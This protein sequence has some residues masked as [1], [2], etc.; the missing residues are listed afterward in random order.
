MTRELGAGILDVRAT[1]PPNTQLSNER[2]MTEIETAGVISRVISEVWG[3]GDLN[4]ADQLFAPGYIN[5][6]GFTPDAIRGPESIKLAVALYRKAFPEL[7][8]HNRSPGPRGGTTDVQLESAKQFFSRASARRR[9][10]QTRIYCWHD[11][12]P[13]RSRPDRRE[14]D[15]SGMPNEKCDDSLSL[16]SDYHAAACLKGSDLRHGGETMT[17]TT[18][19]LQIGGFRFVA[20]DSYRWP[21]GA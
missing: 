9:A 7:P 14:L 8:D 16:A 13:R 12:G 19:S 20:S 1:V 10:D 21:L 18:L 6:G 5:H 2:A 4:L 17:G 11:V 15:L 3:R